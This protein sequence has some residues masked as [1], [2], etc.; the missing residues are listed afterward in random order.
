[1]SDRHGPYFEG[2]CDDDELMGRSLSWWQS[3]RTLVMTVIPIVLIIGAV[4]AAV[5]A[6]E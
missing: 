4:D 1:M 2:E 6:G 3:L 5:E